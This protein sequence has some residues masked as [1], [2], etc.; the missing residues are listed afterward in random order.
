M[1]S[2][3][4]ANRY[5]RLAFQLNPM[6]QAEQ[7]MDLRSRALR[8]P[9]L[10]K[11]QAVAGAGH[12]DMMALKIAARQQIQAIQSN[13]WKLPLDSLQ[14]QLANIDVRRLPELAPVVERLRTTAACRAQF[15][16]LS[17]ESWMDPKLF[18]AFKTAVVLPPAE[19]GHIREFFLS[20]IGDKHQ[21]KG[22]KKAAQM[23]EAKYPVLYDWNA[24]GFKRYRST[25]FAMW[26]STAVFLEE[27]RLGFPRSVGLLRWPYCSSFES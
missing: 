15:P 10:D 24:I 22:L 6:W 25:R 12:D 23:L 18:N 5:L 1:S 2:E 3:T 17:Q 14:Q 9:R 13:F 21:L 19:A 27:Y 20:R 8:L 26:R 16:P 7:L 11:E 4:S